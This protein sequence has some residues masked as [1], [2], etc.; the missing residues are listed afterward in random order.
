MLKDVGEVTA[1]WTMN[2]EEQGPELVAGAKYSL[3]LDW[4]V[5]PLSSFGWI[6]QA[7]DRRALSSPS[8]NMGIGRPID[9]SVI[10]YTQPEVIIRCLAR[11]HV[12]T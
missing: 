4:D 11:G 7:S 5:R 2:N 9:G 12:Y 10:S 6:L 1:S 3:G 8:R